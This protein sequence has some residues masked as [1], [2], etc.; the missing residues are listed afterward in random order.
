MDHSLP[1]CMESSFQGLDGLGATFL[2]AIESQKPGVSVIGGYFQS[3]DFLFQKNT[4]NLNNIKQPSKIIVQHSPNHPETNPSSFDLERSRGPKSVI[5]CT[6]ICARFCR[7]G[8]AESPWSM[9]Y[10]SGCLAWN[11]KFGM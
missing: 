5:S 6:K 7:A 11:L 10:I 3:L 4:P 9:R 1:S 8:S 2:A